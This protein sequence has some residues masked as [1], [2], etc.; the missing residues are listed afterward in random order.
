MHI[1]KYIRFI[2]SSSSLRIVYHHWKLSNRFQSKRL[3]IGFGVSIINS[4]LGFD[5]FVGSNSRI[6]NSSVGDHTYFNSHTNIADAK[7]GKYCSIGSHVKVGIGSHPTSMVST[8]P[9]FYANNKGFNTYADKMY[10]NEEGASIEI[11][12][13]VWIGSN[14]TVLNKIK[15]GHGAIVAIGSIVTKDVPNYAVV[16]GIPAKIIKYRFTDEEIKSL[17]KIQWWDFDQEKIQKHF[18]DFHDVSTFNKKYTND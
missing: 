15:I 12:N 8:H 3:I 10:Y 11:G 9:C 5:V 6:S 2:F 16:A 18:K 4:E 17:L 7:I 14:V 1:L 13:D